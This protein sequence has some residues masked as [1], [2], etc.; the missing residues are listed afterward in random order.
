M[1]NKLIKLIII[2]V[3]IFFGILCAIGNSDG[4][5]GNSE[6]PLKAGSWSQK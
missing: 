5:K 6:E 3:I 1:P 4:N 2:T